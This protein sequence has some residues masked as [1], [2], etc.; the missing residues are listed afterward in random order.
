MA[1]RDV[2]AELRLKPNRRG[3]ITKVELV[4]DSTSSQAIDARAK[5]KAQLVVAKPRVNYRIDRLPQ[6]VPGPVIVAK[7]VGDMNVKPQPIKPRGLGTRYGT[8]NWK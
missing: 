8:R 5:A 4:N 6:T 2:V 7:L 1:V 3:I